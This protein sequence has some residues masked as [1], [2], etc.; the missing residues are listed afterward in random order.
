[1][2]LAVVFISNMLYIS[3]IN[4]TTMNPKNLTKPETNT[5]HVAEKYQGQNI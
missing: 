3:Y 1:M 2:K 5:M 4:Q